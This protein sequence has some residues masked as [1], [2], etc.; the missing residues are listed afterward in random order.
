MS[1]FKKC[2]NG[3]YYQGATCP[4]CPAGNAT[5]TATTGDD[6]T[7]IQGGGR[8][9]SSKTQIVGGFDNSETVGGNTPVGGGTVVNRPAQNVGSRTVIID[10]TVVTNTDGRAEVVQ[11]TRNTRKLVGWL[12]TYSHDAMGVDY[13]IY[14]GR[15]IIGRD[16]ECSI[17]VADSQMSGK[18]ATL[19]FRA[20]KYSLTDQQSTHGTFVNDEDIDLEPRYLH[21]GDVIRM[22]QTV[23]RFKTS[24]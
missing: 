12:V 11:Q 18:H 10:E 19:L 24:L 16:L 5:Q 2:S 7:Q 21:D 14:E 17:S 4:Y 20:D 9:N 3:H 22:G 8:R 13:R 6:E 1:D 23:F 15:N